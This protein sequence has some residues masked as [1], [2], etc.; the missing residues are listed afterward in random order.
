MSE[1]FMV[2][3]WFKGLAP[4]HCRKSGPGCSDTRY[5]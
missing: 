5:I 3:K 4:I 2:E 1:V